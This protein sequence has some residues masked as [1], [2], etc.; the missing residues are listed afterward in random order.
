MGPSL[1]RRLWWG[2]G[3]AIVVGSDTR[4]SGVSDARFEALKPAVEAT[5]KR[6]S[7]ETADE[8]RERRVAGA[9]EVRSV[10]GSGE[11]L[12]DDRPVIERPAAGTQRAASISEYALLERIAEASP[13]REEALLL[14]IQAQAAR[15]HGDEQGALGLEAAAETAGSSIAR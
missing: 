1:L 9:A 3:N 2:E 8:L 15:A 7:I 13:T 14:W 6:L 11:I 4:L 12:S 10:L 5:L